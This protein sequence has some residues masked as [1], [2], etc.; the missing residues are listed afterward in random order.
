MSQIISKYQNRKD[1][2]KHIDPTISDASSNL[3]NI[4]HT[5]NVISNPFFLYMLLDGVGL[6][7]ITACT[8]YD[9][10]E[11][12]SIEFKY[13]YTVS[14]K[15]LYSM[16]N[17]HPV[18]AM[19]NNLY[20]ISPTSASLMT[21]LSDPELN[22]LLDMLNANYLAITYWFVGRAMQVI[23]L[24]SLIMHAGTSFFICTSLYRSITL[25]CIYCYFCFSNFAKI[26]QF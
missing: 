18:A 8:L 12:W 23:G 11:I 17:S 16:Y 24:W 9:A 19:H 25:I 22:D 14:E 20:E 1:A 7:L 10:Y 5:H 6:A 13:N 26:H 2:K 3:K 21:S 15:Q 4:Q